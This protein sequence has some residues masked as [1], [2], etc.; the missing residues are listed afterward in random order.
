MT[1]F[2]NLTWLHGKPQGSGLLKANPEDFV[3]VEDLGFTPDGEGEHILLRIL[4][5]GC[6]TV[7]SLTRWRNSWK[8]HAREVSFAGQK[9]KHALPEQ[10]LCRARAGER[11]ARFQRLS[12]GRL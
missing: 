11:D 6:N 2:D 5:N 7:L 8:I 3:V 10:W 4:K 12:A 9:D 1:E